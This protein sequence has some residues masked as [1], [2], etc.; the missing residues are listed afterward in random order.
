MR[1]ESRNDVCGS[2]GTWPDD[3]RTDRRK[4]HNI[5]GGGR[6][7]FETVILAP[8]ETSGGRGGSSKQAKRRE[9]N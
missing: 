3:S 4:D 9:A 5:K 1:D 2:D 6:C 7:E 8:L